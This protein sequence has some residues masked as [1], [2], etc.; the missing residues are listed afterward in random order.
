MRERSSERSRASA[1]WFAPTS[2]STDAEGEEGREAEREHAPA[3]DHAEIEPG[4]LGHHA[5]IPGRIPDQIEL[6]VA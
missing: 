5:R 1:A 3:S 6:H 4:G 2:T